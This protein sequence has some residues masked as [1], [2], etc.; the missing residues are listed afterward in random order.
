MAGN[1][2]SCHGAFAAVTLGIILREK[3]FATIRK[4][5]KGRNLSYL[6]E[7]CRESASK[8]LGHARSKIK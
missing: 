8:K 1:A 6:G 4:G 2:N 5:S 3:I 7:Q